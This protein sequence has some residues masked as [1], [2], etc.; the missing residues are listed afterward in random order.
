MGLMTDETPIILW[1]DVIKD[2]EDRCAIYLKNDI[3]AYLVTLLL[4]Y[5][6]KP[7]VVKQV[8]ATTFLRAQQLGRE[9]RYITLQQVGDQCLLFAGL[10]P[11]SAHKKQVKISYFVDMGRSAYAAISNQ[12]NDLHALLALQ[13]VAM[14]DVLQSIRYYS[15]LLPLEAYEQWADVGSQ[16]AF[17][18]LQEYTR[19]LPLKR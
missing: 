3:E 4:R 15:D 5:T 17:R 13:F 1:Q 10:F 18:F 6:N 11:Q 9:E 14:I 12:T 7:E 2:A 16:R 19:G 8:I